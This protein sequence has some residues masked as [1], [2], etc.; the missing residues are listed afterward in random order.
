M[1][2]DQRPAG[3]ARY[4]DPHRPGPAHNSFP[5]LVFF[6]VKFCLTPAYPTHFS[7][8]SSLRTRYVPTSHAE[9]GVDKKGAL[10]SHV[11]AA[12][13]FLTQH[14][15]QRTLFPPDRSLPAH[16]LPLCPAPPLLPLLLFHILLGYAGPLI[17]WHTRTLIFTA[18]DTGDL[19]MSSAPATGLS[20]SSG[21]L[22]SS[23]LYLLHSFTPSPST[24]TCT[25][26]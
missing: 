2:L 26:V 23:A 10:G 11:R 1:R 15:A 18:L 14:F 21:F 6:K 13:V 5:A 19:G 24:G 22:I 4:P 9:Q 3:Q 20:S 17:Q 25:A 7:G 12:H 8:E 16:G